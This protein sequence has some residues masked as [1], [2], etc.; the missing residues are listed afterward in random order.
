MHNQL[1]ALCLCLFTLANTAVGEPDRIALE[2]KLVSVDIELPT[3]THVLNV[4]LARLGYPFLLELDTLSYRSASLLHNKTEAQAMLMRYRLH[5]KNVTVE[6]VL[7]F[8]LKDQPRYRYKVIDGAVIHIYPDGIEKRHN[9]PLN[10]VLQDFPIEEKDI[11]E[12]WYLDQFMALAEPMRIDL[13][14]APGREFATCLSPKLFRGFT[15]RQLLIELSKTC[16]TQWVFEPLPPTE[17]KI[18][19]SAWGASAY[20]QGERIKQSGGDWYQLHCL[21]SREDIVQDGVMR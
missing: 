21:G 14:Q 8:I 5:L 17:L 4:F 15:L 7:K 19:I 6:D 13:G 11:S 9:W 10:V 20:P 12:A 2:R 18:R 1:M 3:W 16:R